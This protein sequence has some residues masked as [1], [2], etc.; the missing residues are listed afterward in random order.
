MNDESELPDDVQAAISANRKI[1]AIK[2]LREHR[3]IGL[4]EAKDIVDAYI[5]GHPSLAAN[6]PPRSDTGIG[7][8]VLV[9]LVLAL[10][11]A[12]Y[13]FLS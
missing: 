4:K 10:A 12:G 3:K 6:T 8:V 5:A 1:E 7:R 9:C 11:Y 13:R 2:L